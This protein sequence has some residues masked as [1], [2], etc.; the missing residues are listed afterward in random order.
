MRTGT[1][2]VIQ[3]AFLDPQAGLLLPG[4]VGLQAAA[5]ERVLA[6]GGVGEA[7]VTR[8]G[9]VGGITQHHA[10]Q[11]A[12]EGQQVAGCVQWVAQAV[13]AHVAQRGNQVA[14]AQ[15]KH[16]VLRV[17]AGGGDRCRSFAWFVFHGNTP[18][19]GH[20]LV[21]TATGSTLAARG[22]ARVHDRALTLL[23]EELHDDRGNG[24]GPGD[25]EQVT[26]V[27]NV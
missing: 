8:V 10:P 27:D 16:G 23:L 5:V 14:S 24:L 18:S 9:L 20:G 3:V 21:S 6:P 12:T 4:Q 1:V 11:L 26:V 19:S 22:R 7:A 17:H 15:A 13:A 25:Q 2:I